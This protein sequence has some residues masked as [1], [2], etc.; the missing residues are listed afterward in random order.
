[1][2]SERLIKAVYALGMLGISIAGLMM[3]IEASQRRYGAWIGILWGIG[4]MV[5]GNTLWRIFCEGL[6]LLFSIH[7][8]LSS[9][10]RRLRSFSFPDTSGM[11][12]TLSSIAKELKGGA[13]RLSSI[14]KELKGSLQQIQR[15]QSPPPAI[16]ESEEK[17]PDQ[18][19][20][21]PQQTQPP[22]AE[23]LP[24][25][26]LATTPKPLEQFK[27]RRHRG[28]WIF[29]FLLFAIGVFVAL[30]IISGHA[31]PQGLEP[32]AI[33]KFFV[34]MWDYWVQVVGALE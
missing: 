21:Q 9:I 1:M 26:S 20:S 6:I 22:Q 13:S 7:G 11:R 33:S 31:K 17:Q 29:L 25:Q 16:S 34:G 18:P 28:R 32:Q 14:E 15:A 24:S 10:E 12:E 2:I 30:P 19:V 23:P 8:L 27:P 3:I 4:V 5:V